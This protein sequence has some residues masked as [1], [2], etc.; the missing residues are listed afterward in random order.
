MKT[1]LLLITLMLA[2]T[3]THAQSSIDA[4]ALTAV[5]AIYRHCDR[6]HAVPFRVQECTQE[7]ARAFDR[8]GAR[9]RTHPTAQNEA[10]FRACL[11]RFTGGTAREPW[12]DA[13]GLDRCF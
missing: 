8:A 5:M 10:R 1:T 13:V 9:Y 7:H 6:I 4:G 3:T 2:T 11:R 12:L